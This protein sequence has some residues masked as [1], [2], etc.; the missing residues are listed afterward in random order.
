MLIQFTVSNFLSIKESATLNMLAVKPIKEFEDE[1]VFDV[2][3][4]SLLKSSVIYGA[5]ASGKS[6]ILKAMG[7]FK[8]FAVNSAKETQVDEN[9]DVTPFKLSTETES[10]PSSFEASFLVDGIKYRY[11]FDVDDESVKTEWLLFSTKIKEY[12]LFI[13]DGQMIEVFKEFKEGKGIEDKTRK[14]ALFLSVA[15]QFNGE[16]SKSIIRWFNEFNMISGLADRHFEGFTASLLEDERYKKLIMNLMSDADL[17]FKDI[18]V[19]DV[20]ITSE[21]LPN[22]MP[23][24]LKSILLKEAK[25]KRGYDIETFHEKFDVEG[26]V[27]SLVRFDFDDEES[28]GTKKYFRLAGPILD[29]LEDGGVIIID[30]LDARLH[31]SLTKSIVQLFNTPKV[32]RKNAQLIF[33]T[34]DTNLL[35]ACMFRRDQIWFTEKRRDSS[36]DLYSLAEYKLERGKVRKDAS[37]EKDYIKGR[38]GAIPYVGDFENLLSSSLWQE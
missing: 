12:P 4:Y 29:T 7:F 21:S 19:L 38:Y 32:N 18:N 23:D 26:N 37:F 27:E 16:K 30:E 14:N 2:D 8:W 13:R 6:N 3:R 28:E 10:L 31:P 20:E 33:A 15:A 34:H 36:T 5:N 1:N 24:E 35:S 22:S 17:G 9:I 25:G 11:G